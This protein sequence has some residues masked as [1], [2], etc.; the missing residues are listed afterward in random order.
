MNAVKTALY[1]GGFRELSERVIKNETALK[2]KVAGTN[3]FVMTDL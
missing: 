1:Q 2:L 3:C